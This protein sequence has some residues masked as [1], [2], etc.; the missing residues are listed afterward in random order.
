MEKELERVYI[1]H[2][3]GMGCGTDSY[4]VVISRPSDLDGILDAMA[5]A[6]HEQWYE[7]DESDQDDIEDPECEAE[8]MA[9]EYTPENFEKWDGK[10]CGGGSFL[11]D[12]GVIEAWQALGYG[13]PKFEGSN[14]YDCRA[15]IKRW[16]IP[17]CQAGASWQ[18]LENW[19]RQIMACQDVIRA[20]TGIRSLTACP[21]LLQT[22]V[23]GALAMAENE[24]KIIEAN[25]Q[26]VVARLQALC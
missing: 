10:R 26:K 15:Y 3:S 1:A 13:A 7:P 6:H 23:A 17:I 24:Q 16:S 12:G 19:Q 2:L 20:V 4:D 8:A 9:Y 25:V 5:W 18:E 21:P 11:D 22:Q 14:A